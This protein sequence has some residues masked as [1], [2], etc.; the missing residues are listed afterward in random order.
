MGRGTTNMY[1]P[2]APGDKR[3][4]LV[5]QRP[6]A[7]IWKSKDQW[8]SLGGCCWT[9]WVRN[10]ITEKE[11]FE[12]LEACRTLILTSSTCHGFDSAYWAK[13]CERIKRCSVSQIAYW[14]R[15]LGVQIPQ[16][17]ERPNG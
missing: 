4:V 12:R 13:L 10:P 8:Y 5:G 14:A 9:G 15:E 3:R 6:K 2:L 7:S 16:K 11:A 1:A 17:T